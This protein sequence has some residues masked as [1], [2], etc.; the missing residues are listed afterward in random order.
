MRPDRQLA[1]G[2]PDCCLPPFGRDRRA[3][4]RPTHERTLTR[5][6][7]FHAKLFGFALKEIAKV[8]SSGTR[9]SMAN[10]DRRELWRE[11]AVFFL[12]RL[13]ELFALRL[14]E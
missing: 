13:H 4:K 12:T 11:V 10:L 5:K 14:L 2:C 3:A 1:Q 9:R 7:K 6:M 8:A